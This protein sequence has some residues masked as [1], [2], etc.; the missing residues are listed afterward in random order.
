MM[1]Y[2]LLHISHLDKG[3]EGIP[4]PELGNGLE[5]VHPSIEHGEV[6]RMQGA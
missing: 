3:S 2:I 6:R 5:I 1:L 4:L